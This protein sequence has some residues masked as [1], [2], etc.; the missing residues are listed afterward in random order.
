MEKIFDVS[1]DIYEKVLEKSKAYRIEGMVAE[2]CQTYYTRAMAK[3]ISKD[4]KH[5][6]LTS[7]KEFRLKH[8]ITNEEDFKKYLTDKELPPR[9]GGECLESFILAQRELRKQNDFLQRKVSYLEDDIKKI[10][11]Q[12]ADPRHVEVF[13]IEVLPRQVQRLSNYK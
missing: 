3:K 12:I 9:L 13:D 4:S 6:K 5:S 7:T 2:C 1:R 11:F 8:G 10:D